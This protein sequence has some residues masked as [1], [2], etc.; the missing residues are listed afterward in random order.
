MTVTKELI[1]EIAVSV[2]NACKMGTGEETFADAC[3]ELHDPRTC[4]IAQET[5]KRIYQKIVEVQ[6]YES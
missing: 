1:D 4:E 2:C 5:A 3:W 6:R